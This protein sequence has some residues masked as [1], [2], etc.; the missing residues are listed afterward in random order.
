MHKMP[1]FI[2]NHRCAPFSS[3]YAQFG[4]TYFE[5]ATWNPLENYN[6]STA[7]IQQKHKLKIEGQ[8]YNVESAEGVLA[9]HF[10]A[11]MQIH[12]SASVH[13]PQGQN[14]ELKIHTCDLSSSSRSS[15]SDMNKDMSTTTAQSTELPT[16]EGTT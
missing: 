15:D 9:S 7:N 12:T 3:I 16:T 8:F 13:F 14:Q 6:H 4:H 2:C 11:A 5:N 1:F 10:A